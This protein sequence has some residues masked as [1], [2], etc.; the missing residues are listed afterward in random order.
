MSQQ[1]QR[2]TSLVIG[3]EDNQSVTIGKDI[4]VTPYA[5]TPGRVKLRIVAPPDVQVVRDNAV[6][7]TPRPR[8]VTPAA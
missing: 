1:A 5:C 7:R 8:P 6:R 4:T 3:R 2:F